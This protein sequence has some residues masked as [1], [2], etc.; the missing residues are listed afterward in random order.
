MATIHNEANKD[1]IAKTVI[2]AGDPERVK[3][4]AEKYLSN[5]KLVNSVRG[6]LA[7]TGE[8]KETKVTVMAHGMGMP[9][10]GIYVYELFKFYNVDKIIR[11]GTCGTNNLSVNLL[12][13]LLE[14]NSYTESNY[15]YTLN[16]ENVKIIEASKELNNKIL[17]VAVINNILIKKG[18][19]LTSDCFDWYVTDFN[20]YDARIPKE[21]NI[22]G[23]EMESFAILY[24]AKL[25]RKEATCLLTVVDSH[26]KE[27][28]IN[29][30]EKKDA[31]DKMIFLAL[32]SIN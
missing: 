20:K 28:N 15:A 22:L 3:Y 14:E 24:L 16:N 29:D 13:I 19:I 4:I 32:E 30:E 12:D 10:A 18:N 9:S 25:F 21:L 23:T 5:I 8:Y 6:M 7:Y 1:D 2:M 17:N 31:I 26:I 11:L 27:V